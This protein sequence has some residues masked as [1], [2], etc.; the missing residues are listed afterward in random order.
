MTLS[1]KISAIIISIIGAAVCW[2]ANV[3][4]PF[5]LGPMFAC[6]IA[7][8]GKVP[9][10]GIKPLSD[11]MRTILG[12]AVGASITPE[13]FGKIGSMAT[14]VAMVPVFVLIIGL[15]GVPYFK[16]ICGFDGPTSY[17]ASMPGGLQDMLVFGEEAGADVR[18]LSLVHATRVLIIVSALPFILQGWWELDLSM[19]P[20]AP[21]KSMPIDQ[22][23]LMFLAAGFG[24]WGAIKIKLF[25][26]SILGPLI[27]AAAL[28]L[29]GLLHMR[30]PAEAIW[31]SQFFIGISVGVKYAGITPKELRHDLLAGIGFCLILLM[32]SA[33][34]VE[35]I[36]ALNLAPPLETVL[37]FSPG[38]QAEM[39][40]L[41][42]VAGADI[43]F[44]VAHHVVRIVVV[45]ICAPIFGRLIR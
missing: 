45:I 35:I 40:V 32:L 9:M 41:A 44:V 27:A 21:V 5:L 12:V 39:A 33:G 28:S 37:A 14:T 6:L 26:A 4:L 31:I 17:Y 25:G 36:I 8:I 11:G 23:I 22:I 10:A 34:F 38:G 7:A 2:A 13:L 1:P 42:I 3:P 30:P 18:A 20:G 19:P 43:A 15:I 29:T 16:R 24:W